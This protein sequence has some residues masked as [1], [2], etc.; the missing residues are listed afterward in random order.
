MNKYYVY[1]YLDP[2]KQGE[3]NFD[4][5]K[6]DY[7]P[8]YVGKGQKKRAWKHLKENKENP[9]FSYKIKKIQRTLGIDPIILIFRKHLCEDE[10]LKLECDLIRR[11]GRRD[12]NTGTLCN[13]TDGGDGHPSPNE[14]TRYKASQYNVMKRPEFRE[15]MCGES[16]MAKRPEIRDKI[17]K[18]RRSLSSIENPNSKTYSITDSNGKETVVKCL[19]EWCRIHDFNYR[20]CRRCVKLYGKFC[21]YIIINKTK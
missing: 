8:I 1:I 20:S 9:G 17:S 11:I 16:N 15:R 12:L 13:L 14:Y 18:Y 19:K 21:G 5:I 10:A 2:R 7:E 6:L 3:Y 4:D